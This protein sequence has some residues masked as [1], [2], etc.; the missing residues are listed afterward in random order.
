[1][2]TLCCSWVVA[3]EALHRFGCIFCCVSRWKPRRGHP[4]L[5]DPPPPHSGTF[6]TAAAQR[7]RRAPRDW[8]EEQL[9]TQKHTHLH[10]TI[11]VCSCSWLS[12]WRQSWVSEDEHT[13]L[14]SL[15]PVSMFHGLKAHKHIKKKKNLV[16]QEN[17]CC[18]SDLRALKILGR[19][20][21]CLTV[22][23]TTL[24]FRSF[25]KTLWLTSSPHHPLTKVNHNG[26]RWRGEDIVHHNNL[27]QQRQPF[28][29]TAVDCQPLYEK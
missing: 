12:T 19:H 27:A 10:T 20:R 28:H 15:Y 16:S 5:K 13:Y 2:V 6:T 4:P 24:F 3:T 9:C 23:W 22:L 29:A 8:W 7:S 18:N 26:P 17:R 21:N 25:W 14:W 1:M 11:G